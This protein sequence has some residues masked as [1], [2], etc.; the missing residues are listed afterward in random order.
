MVDVVEIVSDIY[1][2]TTDYDERCRYFKEKYP[3]FVI[4]YT[5]LFEMICKP[6]FNFDKFMEISCNLLKCKKRKYQCN[7]ILLAPEILL[8][9]LNKMFHEQA[10]SIEYFA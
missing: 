6:R 4:E 7:G 10:I 2:S 8:P 9:Q 5:K 1:H 3:I